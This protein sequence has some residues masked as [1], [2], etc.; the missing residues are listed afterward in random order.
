MEDN[1]YLNAMGHG[2]FCGKNCARD[3][4]AQ[5]IPPKRGRKNIAR[6]TD[7]QASKNIVSNAGN[8]SE[9][10]SSAGLIV[11]GLVAAGLVITVVVLVIKKRNS[12]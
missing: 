2:I 8:T 12:N 1:T 3:R 6:F 10:G 7:L 4:E 9:G 5:G 11:G